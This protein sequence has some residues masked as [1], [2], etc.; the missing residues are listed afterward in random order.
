MGFHHCILHNYSFYPHLKPRPA[1]QH[2][3]GLRF[4]IYYRFLQNSN[5]SN[6]TSSSGTYGYRL[7]KYSKQ[8]PSYYTHRCEDIWCTRKIKPY[9]QQLCQKSTHHTVCRTNNGGNFPLQITCYKISYTSQRGG[10]YHARKVTRLRA[11]PP[12][13]RHSI[14]GKGKRFFSSTKCLGQ[15]F[16]PPDILFSWY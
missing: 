4:S 16:C 15:L 9:P 12:G 2:F 10:E 7:H 11:G 1:F 5:S 6:N 14:P 8:N 13:N 3:K